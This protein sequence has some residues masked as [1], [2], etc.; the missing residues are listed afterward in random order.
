M[1]GSPLTRALVLLGVII[2]LGWPL[3]RLTSQTGQPSSQEAAAAVAPETAAAIPVVLTFSRPALKVEVRHL[4]KVVWARTTPAL[5]ERVELS[6]PF[7][8]EG[9]ELGVTVEWEG[10]SIGALRMQLSPPEGSELE[11]SVWGSGSVET[12]VS[13]P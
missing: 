11:R 2:L 4:E 6:I 9:V 12:V 8:K 10:E 5:S 3:H 13:F 7:P 1:K